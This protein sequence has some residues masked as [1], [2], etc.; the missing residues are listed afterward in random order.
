[1]K[2]KANL[3][4]KIYDV[5]EWNFEGKQDILLRDAEGNEIREW[6]KNLEIT[7][8]MGLSITPS[9]YKHHRLSISA[10]LSSASCLMCSLSPSFSPT[11]LSSGISPHALYF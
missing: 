6:I 5:I 4:D 2:F 7:Y 10:I 3:Q 1:M 8:L 11:H 9:T